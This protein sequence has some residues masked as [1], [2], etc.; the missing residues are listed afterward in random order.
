MVT[1]GYPWDSAKKTEVID[2]EH[3]LED[4]NV[5][6]EDLN[7]FPMEIQAAVS[8]NLESLPI[9]CG[10]RFHNGS[11]H[12]SD[13]C[14]KYMDGGWQHFATMINRR[15]Y[16][17][18]IVYGNALHI[19]GGFDYDTWTKLQSSETINIDG[20]STEGPKL[21]TPIYVHAI[22][23]INSAVSI[24]SGGYT[25][26]NSYSRLTWY[27]NHATHEFQPGPSLLEDRG[28]H[29]SGTII[30]ENTK[31]RI[32]IIAGGRNDN[33]FFDSTEML[34]NGKWVTGKSHKY[35][36][37]LSIFCRFGYSKSNYHIC[38]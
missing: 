20:S 27:F 10:G 12:S 15:A 16:A 6:C 3:N 14:F 35:F 25:N 18:G 36:V 11:Y 9:I 4:S 37:D 8:A 34:I 1:T 30:D 24:I 26:T 2:L 38:M 32:V 23:A 7:D 29:S 17:T 31:E 13:K 22:A 33:G 5:I 19:F 28:Y 21:P